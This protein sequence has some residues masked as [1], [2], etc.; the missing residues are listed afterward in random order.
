MAVL[1]TRGEDGH[2][3]SPNNNSNHATSASCVKVETGFPAPFNLKAA[4]S[5]H[6]A[7]N[8]NLMDGILCVKMC[9]RL[10]GEERTR[11]RETCTHAHTHTHT[12]RRGK[13]SYSK[14]SRAGERERKK[15]FTRSGKKSIIIFFLSGGLGEEEG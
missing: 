15:S 1:L 13:K 14:N 9:P 10:T 4:K 7:F 6:S 5:S 3:H 2:V 12:L 8:H 11:E